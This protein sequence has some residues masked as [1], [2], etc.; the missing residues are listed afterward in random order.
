MHIENVAVMV[1]GV[2]SVMSCSRHQNELQSLPSP[3]CHPAQS[4][5]VTDL[6]SGISCMGSFSA[7]PE[8]CSLPGM[9][10]CGPLVAVT[11]N[12]AVN[13]HV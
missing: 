9:A 2:F 8:D 6:L 3:A 13:V 5:P 12:T 4:L 10:T 11:S 1:L 7:V